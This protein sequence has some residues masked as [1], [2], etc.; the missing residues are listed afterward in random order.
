MNDSV[1][2]TRISCAAHS[3][4]ARPSPQSPYA[5]ATE[6]DHSSASVRPVM[7]TQSSSSS[8]STGVAQGSSVSSSTSIS[9]EMRMPPS[10]PKLGMPPYIAVLPHSA[11]VC[12]V[13]AARMLYA[14]LDRTQQCRVVSSSPPRSCQRITLPRSP[15]SGISAL[16]RRMMT[17]PPSTRSCSKSENAAMSGADMNRRCIHPPQA[18]FAA[19]MTLM[20]M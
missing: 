20:P 3:V 14:P 17:P 6:H 2:R 12:P 10:A 16:S 4:T 1:S 19:A 11:R 8:H 18:V 9:A 5:A 13:F 15:R 7:R